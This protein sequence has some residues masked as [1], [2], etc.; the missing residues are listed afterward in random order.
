MGHTRHLPYISLTSLARLVT[1][2][3]GARGTIARP[4]LFGRLIG[5]AGWLRGSY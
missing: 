4:G 2:S 5:A 1:V 3:C